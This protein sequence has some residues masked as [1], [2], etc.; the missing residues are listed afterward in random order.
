VSE[1]ERLLF[2][3][4]QVGDALPS[5]S[6]PIGISDIVAMSIAT[7]D[8]HPV[9]HDAEVARAAGHPGLFINIMSTSGLIERF[10]RAWSRGGRVSQLKLRL[11]V[12]HYA[13]DTL[14]FEG[15]VMAIDK[16]GGGGWADLEYQATNARGRHASG[17]LKV[18]WR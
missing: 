6:V 10:V 17:Q 15:R 9:H 7:R 16:Q 3:R 11:G 4:L 2:E 14:R 13:G 8:F 1:A 12:P 5:L 18:V